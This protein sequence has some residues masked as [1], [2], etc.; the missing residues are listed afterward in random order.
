MIHLLRHA[1]GHQI[2]R[3]GWFDPRLGF[4]LIRDRRVSVG[5]KALSLALGLGVTVGLEALEVPLE[6]I[7]AAMMPVLGIGLDVAIAG[8]E[9]VAL[10]IVFG[11][12]LLTYLAPKATVEAVRQG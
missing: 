7:L 10:P 12:V 6:S 8:T 2:K 4:R 9:I 11:A 3:Q 1:V 5:L